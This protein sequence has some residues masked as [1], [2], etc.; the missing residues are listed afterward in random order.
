MILHYTEKEELNLT[1]TIMK[2][3][4][5]TILSVV[6][7]LVVSNEL[8]AQQLR[9]SYF[10]DKSIVRGNM[11]PALRPERGYVNIPVIS[12]IGMSFNSNALTVDNIF[13]KKNGK[14]VTFLDE[15]IAADKFL[16]TLKARNNLNIDFATNVLGFGFWVL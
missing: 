9:T 6:L 11:N 3:F 10:M 4:L 7:L 12:G 1:N 2:K 14:V 8:A 15:S 5:H 13:A 16:S